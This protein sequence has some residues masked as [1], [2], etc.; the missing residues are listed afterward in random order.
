MS[1]SAIRRGV[2]SVCV[3]GFTLFSRT[4]HARTQ[5]L[6]SLMHTVQ[7]QTTLSSNKLPM[8]S[9]SLKTAVSHHH[10]IL[11]RLKK[12]Q[13]MKYDQ[14]DDFDNQLPLLSPALKH[15]ASYGPEN[16]G[17]EQAQAFDFQLWNGLLEALGN[18]VC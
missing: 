16:V 9:P 14:N 2:L 4:P 1:S 5:T 8:G 12:T 18:Q 13:S 6:C 11:A 17:T 15:A 7:R 3:A 10:T